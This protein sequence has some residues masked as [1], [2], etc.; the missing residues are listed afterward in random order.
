MKFRHEVN[1]SSG[2]ISVDP[3]TLS[4][5]PLEIEYPINMSTFPPTQPYR[6]PFASLGSMSSASRSQ[7]AALGSR[8]CSIRYR[9]S[10]PFFP[11]DFA[12]ASISE[13]AMQLLGRFTTSYRVCEACYTS[14]AT[15]QRSNSWHNLNSQRV[16]RF[17]CHSHQLTVPRAEDRC[18]TQQP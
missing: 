1:S 17:I 8:D 6:Q 11:R 3:Q 18:S 12:S 16:A 4:S 5:S 2:L 7:L 13:I 15:T 9:R 14:I 10:A